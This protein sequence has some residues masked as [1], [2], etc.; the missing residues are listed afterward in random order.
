MTKSDNKLG[1]IFIGTI[2]VLAIITTIFVYFVQYINNC[3]YPAHDYMVVNI[4]IFITSLFIVY[5]L[6]PVMIWILKLMRFIE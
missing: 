3:C 6:T 5:V 1:W 2:T 4:V